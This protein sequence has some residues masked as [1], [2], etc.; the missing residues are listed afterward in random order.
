[1][2]TLIVWIL[3]SCVIIAQPRNKSFFYEINAFPE[4]STFNVF[5][6]YRISFDKLYFVKQNDKYVSGIKSFVE[7]FEDDIIIDR[8]SSQEKIST[9]DYSETN[10]SQKYLQGFIK[11]KL[12]EG[13][14]KLHPEFELNNTQRPVRMPPVDIKL[15]LKDSVQV[16][17]PV[18]VNYI[19]G[20]DADWFSIANYGGVIPFSKKSYSVLLPVR[21]LISD[22]VTVEIKQKD[23]IKTSVRAAKVFSSV[24]LAKTNP[25]YLEL[26]GINRAKNTSFYLIPNFTSKLN[27]GKCT[28]SIYVGESIISNDINISWVSKPRSLFNP[29]FAINILKY[30]EKDSVISRLLSVDEENYYVTLNEHWR[31]YDRNKNTSFNEVMDEYYSRVDSTNFKFRTTGADIGAE[32]DRG[33]IYIKFGKPDKIERSYVENNQIAELWIYKN[34]NRKFLFE[35]KTGL[36]NY[37]LIN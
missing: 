26:S 28:F 33:R 15:E 6:S 22:S 35:D 10:S 32:T 24:Q 18:A 5:F 29:E 7:V 27:E 9:N 14:F 3:L 4:D 31:K 2:R 37:T 36:G 1:M 30:I 11:L 13:S 20:S 8:T 12:G 25:D 17:K 23:S 34:I 21:N 19:S 16:F